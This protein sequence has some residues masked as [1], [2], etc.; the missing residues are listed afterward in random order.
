[1]S[2]HHRLNINQTYESVKNML[3]QQAWRMAARHNMTF[4]ESLSECHA[5]FVKLFH[6]YFDDR[7]GM[8]FS[9]RLQMGI[10]H[11]SLNIGMKR[12]KRQEHWVPLEEEHV[13]FAP[14]TRSV[15]LEA[16]GDLSKDAQTVVKLLLN[17]PAEIVGVTTPKS[18]LRKTVQFMQAQG[19]H[20]ERVD[21]ACIEVRQAFTHIWATG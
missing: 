13:G 11:R 5:E 3:Y 15:C 19:Y 16:L 21:A 14:D 4:E 17:T 6:G 2:R 1:M 12:A 8:K 10:G 18:L 7:R 9:T 20:K